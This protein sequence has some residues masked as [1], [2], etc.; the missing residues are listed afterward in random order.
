MFDEAY[1]FTS[2]VSSLI[3][4]NGESSYLLQFC[5][6]VCLSV[7]PSLPIC[8]QSEWSKEHICVLENKRHT[9]H[10]TIAYLVTFWCQRLWLILQVDTRYLIIFDI[11]VYI[12]IRPSCIYL[13]LLC[14]LAVCLYVWVCLRITLLTDSSRP[15]PL[16]GITN[17]SI[18]RRVYR[19]IWDLRLEQWTYT[20]FPRFPYFNTSEMEY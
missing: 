13:C 20:Q 7:C 4:R 6:S 14:M 17:R 11:C 19:Q 12:S 16:M 9:T 3:D 8:F 10:A 15:R 5:L 2:S 18:K 1:T